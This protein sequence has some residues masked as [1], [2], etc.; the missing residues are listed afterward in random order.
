LIDKH[1]PDVVQ[2]QN[3][4]PQITPYAYLTCKKNKIPAIQRVSN[5]RFFVQKEFCLKMERY[6][7]YAG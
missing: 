4:Y 1:Q 5:Y 2:F 6:A 7:N 3:I